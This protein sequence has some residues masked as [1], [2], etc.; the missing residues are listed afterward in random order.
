MLSVLLKIVI[1]KSVKILDSSL[2]MARVKQTQDQMTTLLKEKN[3]LS[4]NNIQM[5][6]KHTGNLFHAE[7]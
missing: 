6:C 5:E 1:K 7:I 2:E 4:V 3:D